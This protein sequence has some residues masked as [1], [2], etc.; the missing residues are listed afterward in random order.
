MMNSEQF[1][2]VYQDRNQK[3]CRNAVFM[4]EIIDAV[5]SEKSFTKWRIK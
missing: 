5:V 4:C 2:D 1:I 3:I